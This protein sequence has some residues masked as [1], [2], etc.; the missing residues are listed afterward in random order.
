MDEFAYFCDLATFLK[1]SRLTK[2]DF[3]SPTANL[4]C[5]FLEHLIQDKQFVNWD[6]KVTSLYKI[7]KYSFLKLFFPL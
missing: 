1:V 6:E 5:I 3:F 7:G 4:E 2:D